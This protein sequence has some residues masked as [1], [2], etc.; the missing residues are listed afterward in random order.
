VPFFKYHSGQWSIVV[1]FNVSQLLKSPLG[2]TRKYEVDDE[3]KIGEDNSRVQGEI[4]MLRTNRGILV[5]GKIETEL[6]L[7]CSRCLADFRQ[8]VALEIEEEYFPTIDIITGSSISAPDDEPDAFMIDQ[9][10]ILDLSEAIRQYGLLAVPMKPL[11]RDNCAGLC[12]TCGTN[13]N[14]KKCHCPPIID[15]RFE[16][17]RGLVV[18]K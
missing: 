2:S 16:K 10:N 18:D 7:T 13:L 15:P 4:T 3:V 17:L 5:T 9:N 14:L 8:P 6:K 1:Q 11:C 12:A